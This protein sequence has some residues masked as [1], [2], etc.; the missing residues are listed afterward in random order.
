MLK[1]MPKV[2]TVQNYINI[3]EKLCIVYGRLNLPIKECNHSIIMEIIPYK[4]YKDMLHASCVHALCKTQL[5]S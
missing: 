3:K 5:P 2:S 4:Q 1:L